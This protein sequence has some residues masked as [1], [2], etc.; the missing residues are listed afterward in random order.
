[1]TNYQ[2]T[3][4]L[5]PEKKGQFDVTLYFLWQAELATSKETIDSKDLEREEV[6]CQ[7]EKKVEAA[8]LL[9]LE[10]EALAAEVTRLK[11]VEDA[12]QG[13]V[14]NRERKLSHLEDKM[15]DLQEIRGKRLDIVSQNTL[16][17]LTSA[18]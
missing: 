18:L 17:T 16:C 4:F 6:S 2:C 15:A 3:H 5:Y 12:L 13:K 14:A 7:L 9:Q 10:V 8:T 1:M 11:D